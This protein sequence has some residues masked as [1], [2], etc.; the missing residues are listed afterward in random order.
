M[1]GVTTVGAQSTEDADG[2]DQTEAIMEIA[3]E[4]WTGDL[5]EMKERRFIRVL[6]SYSKTNFF[7]VAG[8]TRGFEYELAEEYDKFLNGKT[9]RGRRVQMVYVPVPFDDLIPALRE[10]RGD[11]I[12]AGMTI[13]PARSDLVQFTEPYLPAVDEIVV[14]NKDVKGLRTTDDLSGRNLLLVSGSSYIP[15]V[16]AL[17]E[18]LS[19]RGHVAIGVRIAPPEF[20]AED[21]LE[22][23]NAGIVDLTIVDNHIGELW[24]SVMPDLVAYPDLIVNKEGEIAWA[25]RE[26]SPE[27]LE[28][29]NSFVSKHRRGSELGNILFKRYYENEKWITNPIAP[30]KEELFEKYTTLFKEYAEE[31]DFDWQ[32]VAALAYQESAFDQSRHSSHGAVGLMQIKPSTARD[33]NVNIPDIS[34][35]KNNV[36]A[37]VKYLAFLRER[38]FSEAHIEPAARVRFALAAY[39]A[40]PGNVAKMRKITAKENLDP[41]KWFGNVAEVTLRHIGSQPVVYVA[42]INKYYFAYKLADEKLARRTEKLDAIKARAEDD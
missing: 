37:G 22:L 25:V 32:L 4:P 26:D 29:L 24:A 21:V 8:Q 30:N 18:D 14:A 7:I 39:N 16:K 15:H 2:V 11:I 13:T 6:V 33:A 20:E 3:H 23:V 5:D 10:G 36:H 1:S 9:K 41:D 35:A 12:A 19:R 34:S 31:Y 38:Y 28:S 27:L 17:S 40:G 42:N